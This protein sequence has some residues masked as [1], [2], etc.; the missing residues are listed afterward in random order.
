MQYSLSK[1]NFEQNHISDIKLGSM[2]FDF[3]CINKHTGKLMIFEY[4]KRGEN[5]PDYITPLTSHINLYIRQNKGKFESYKQAQEILGADVYYI[6]YAFENTPIKNKDN[7]TID[8]GE[9]VKV[10][11]QKSIVWGRNSTKKDFYT[12][13]VKTVPGDM[14]FSVIGRFSTFEQ[15]GDW[16]YNFLSKNAMSI[17]AYVDPI[18]NDPHMISHEEAIAFL[19]D[20]NK[21]YQ[22]QQDKSRAGISH[23]RRLIM[24]DLGG[25][26]LENRLKFELNEFR[27][28]VDKNFYLPTLNKYIFLNYIEVD[29][30]PHAINDPY[31]IVEPIYKKM[32][33]LLPHFAV[34]VLYN[35]ASD[36]LTYVKIFN[37]KITTTKM[38]IEDFR[39]VMFS[40]S[41]L[42]YGGK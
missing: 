25:D 17:D 35:S 31:P 29:G 39:T 27:L 20:K 23:R 28:Q 38:S 15:F 12:K 9:L 8:A 2:N 36:N 37:N 3:I 11:K 1:F 4:L 30:D 10:M 16:F 34:F 33:P 6:N 22:A 40:V 42:Q 5:Q 32:G 41:K 7:V 14:D 24:P 13:E 19:K 21:E 18:E 26:I